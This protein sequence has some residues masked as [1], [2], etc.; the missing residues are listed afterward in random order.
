[1][2]TVSST[3]T[4]PST[5]VPV[6]A[7]ALLPVPVF[8]LL[9][10]VAA[11]FDP[12]C[13]P[14]SG[15]PFER[16]TPKTKL[17]RTASAKSASLTKVADILPE[18]SSYEEMGQGIASKIQVVNAEMNDTKVTKHQTSGAEREKKEETKER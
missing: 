12:L 13:L 14:T 5:A 2:V 16:G 18:R 17:G 15:F 8:L 10:L 1:M 9:P 3:T 7:A 11:L 4:L 6:V